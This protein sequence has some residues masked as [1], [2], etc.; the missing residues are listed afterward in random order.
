MSYF[1]PKVS[2]QKIRR[3]MGSE[4]TIDYEIQKIPEE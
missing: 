1:G 4:S 2:I 3:N